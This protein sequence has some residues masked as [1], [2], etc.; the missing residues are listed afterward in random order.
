MKARILKL[1]KITVEKYLKNNGQN[2]L[3]IND[4]KIFKKITVEKYL[5]S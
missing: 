1:E 3:K 2:I 5:N 4:K